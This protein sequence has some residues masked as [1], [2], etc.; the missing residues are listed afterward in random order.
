M[1]K[2]QAPDLFLASASPR[3]KLL[4]QQC[5]LTFKVIKTKTDE[6]MVSGE[7]PED[8]VLRLSNQKATQ[9]LNTLTENRLYETSTLVVIGSDT[10]VCV[11]KTDILGKPESVK[12]AYKMLS[13]ISGKK[14][15][16]YTAYTILER[17]P[18]KKKG[19]TQFMYYALSKVVETKVTIKRLS[20]REIASYIKTKEP[21]DKA[22]AYAAQGMGMSFIEKIE[23][24]YTNVVGLPMKELVED[25]E[26]EF[27]VLPYWRLKS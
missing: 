21:M 18:L 13:K 7:K 14:H 17:S 9:A 24:S 10:T 8:M 3:R 19:E 27:N 15:S 26:L 22:G 16:V 6:S 20:R 12:E 25:L 5:G 11:E 1:P 23:G 2:I 4:L